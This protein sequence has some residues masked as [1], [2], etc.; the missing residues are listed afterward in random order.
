M[1]VVRIL[2]AAP[3]ST[4]AFGNDCPC[5]CTVTIGFPMSSYFMGFSILDNKSDKVPTIWTVGLV[6]FLLFGFFMHASLMVFAYIGMS[7]IAWRR[8]IFIHKFFNYPK[9]SKLGCSN[10]RGMINRSGNGG[11]E[12]VTCC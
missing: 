12:V 5:I 2:I 9:R 6:V 7:W 3:K 1:V 8:G 11:E 4:K 10:G